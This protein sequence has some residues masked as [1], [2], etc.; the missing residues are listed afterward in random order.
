MKY[1]TIVCLCLL[2]IVCCY[3]QCKEGFDNANTYD[4]DN[5]RVQ[6]YTQQD[7]Q[8]QQE[9]TGL[10]SDLTPQG[11]FTNA[12]RAIFGDDVAPAQEPVDPYCP[13]FDGLESCGSTTNIGDH[14]DYNDGDSG[15][16][17]Y[18]NGSTNQGSAKNQCTA[19]AM[20]HGQKAFVRE[21]YGWYCDALKE[22]VDD[23]SQPDTT[24]FIYAVNN[25]D[26]DNACS[27][28]DSLNFKQKMTCW[29]FGGYLGDMFH[30]YTVNTSGSCT[31][32][33][34]AARAL[35]WGGELVDDIIDFF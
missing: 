3:A 20:C 13:S 31:A 2:L 29:L 26:W 10:L 22:C 21:Y 1:I 4:T 11:I 23:A 7:Y 14:W 32:E 17:N 6:E 30:M 35:Q 24:P 28:S 27:N 16:A 8:Y 18:E 25:V 5:D 19:C 34:Q 9:D 15:F 12:S 33:V